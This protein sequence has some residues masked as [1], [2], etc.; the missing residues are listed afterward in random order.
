M[1]AAVSVTNGFG[2]PLRPRLVGIVHRLS[3]QFVHASGGF[4]CAGSLPAD[5]R[6]EHGDLRDVCGEQPATQKTDRL[7]FYARRE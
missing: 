5:P 6:T 3:G 7:N 1:S 2:R 4:Q